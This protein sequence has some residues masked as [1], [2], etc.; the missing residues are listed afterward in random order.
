MK[1]ALLLALLALCA[2]AT[3][4]AAW[5]EAAAADYAF[6]AAYWGATPTGCVD[7][8]R[9]VVPPAMLPAE[10]WGQATQPKPGQHIE[11]V[12]SIRAGLPRCPRRIVITH[13]YGHLLGYGHSTDPSSIMFPRVATTY[14]PDLCP[15]QADPD[16]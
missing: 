5:N 7:V 3:A 8:Y 2:P 12:I 16:A 11:C 1:R 10:E 15:W 13:E 4:H 14:R 9:Q 6:A